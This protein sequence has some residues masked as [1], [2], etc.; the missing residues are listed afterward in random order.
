MSIPK[1]WG[2][3][4]AGDSRNEI[5]V[6][7][8]TGIIY[9]IT[10]NGRYATIGTK[11]GTKGLAIG[12]GSGNG[13]TASVPYISGTPDTTITWPSGSIPSTFTICSITRYTGATNRDRILEGIGGDWL[14]GHYGGSVAFVAY[15][16]GILVDNPKT[17]TNWLVMCGGNST[18]NTN[19]PTPGNMLVNGESSGLGNGGVGNLTLGIGA[20]SPSNF[21][22]QQVFIWDVAL[23]NAQLLQVSNVMMSY[24]QTGNSSGI[25]T[26][27]KTQLPTTPSLPL[28]WGA[29]IAGDPRNEINTVDSSG[30]I[31]DITGNGR[32]ATIGT[33]GGT[34]GLAIGTGS[35]NGATAS[36]PY[37]S[38]TPDTTITWPSG[39]IP[40]TFTICS[41]TRYTGAS[42]RD[43]ILE[44][45]TGDWL[46]GHYGGS[47]A[48][49]A[50]GSSQ[51]KV[52]N[53]KTATNW[54]VMCGGN[55]SDNTNNPTP[56][57]MLVN[58]ESSG[59]ANGGVGNLTLGIGAQ[60]GSNFSFQQVLI[61]NVALTNAQ[62]LQVSNAMMSYLQTGYNYNIYNIAVPIPSPWGAYVAGNTNNTSSLLVDRTGNERHATISGTEVEVENGIGNVS[63]IP[64]LIGTTNTVITWPIGSV[65]RL[66]T[67]CS[68]TRYTGTTNDVILGSSNLS[69]IHGHSGNSS[70][71][72]YNGGTLKTVAGSS[73]N[74]DWIIM[75]GSSITGRTPDN[76]LVNGVS[77]GVSDYGTGS[78][79][80]GNGILTINN[81]SGRN[82]TFAFQQITIWDVELTTNQLFQVSNTMNDYIQTGDD[83]NLNNV[84]G[85]PAITYTKIPCFL[86]GSKILRLNMDTNVE[87][88]VPVES[89]RRGDLIKTVNHGFRSIVVIGKKH[90]SEPLRIAEKNS[91]LYW[92]R[93]SRIAELKDDLCVTGDH[94]VLY[95]SISDEKKEQILNYMGKIYIT[96]GHYRVPAFLDDRSEPH[97]DPANAT[98]WHFALDNTNLYHNYGVYANGLLVETSSINFMLNYSNLKL[99]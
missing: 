88:Y 26:L 20:G 47:V 36:V 27:A 63:S 16:S 66:F 30:I 59:L 18:N 10:G 15:G 78:D 93:K 89:L 8:S 2:A 77:K 61:W 4:I 31:F 60:Y 49:V 52:N 85:L 21:S 42:N 14:H 90:I 51:I 84:L 70:G 39:S 29:Y 69:F 1:P 96:D 81:Y 98:V 17:A 82:S 6:A 3:Y 55:S 79:N 83:T 67:I 74:T 46:H 34:K 86:Q 75:C 23:T 33:K 91:R 24:L 80:T 9:D 5:S 72:A 38:G 94:C 43:R 76:I 45:T 92:F 12:T 40:S 37:I 11:G 57:N 71:V 44:G 28:P 22:F 99:V 87:E 19:N 50:Y 32:H 41:I 35:G 54:L 58:G 73:G 64:Y 13:A 25:Y 62:L 53:P 56:G 65:P 95:K 68:I 48:F 97:N 7:N